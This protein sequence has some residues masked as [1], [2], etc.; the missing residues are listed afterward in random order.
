MKSKA[1]I[2]NIFNPLASALVGLIDQ[3]TDGRKSRP[4]KANIIHKL[5]K[6]EHYYANNSI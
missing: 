3:K 5:D 4:F 2:V 1:K 6:W